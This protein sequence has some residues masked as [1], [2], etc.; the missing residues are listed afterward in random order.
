MTLDDQTTI[1][2]VI[3]LERLSSLIRLP[4]ISEPDG[5]EE[6]A[7]RLDGAAQAVIRHAA[8]PAKDLEQARWDTG[9]EW[10]VGLIFAL[11]PTDDVKD[12]CTHL[13]KKS[14]RS[15]ETP[16]TT[17]VEPATAES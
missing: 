13:L 12:L 15:H 5:H 1:D 2:A 3:I 8:I 11:V 14:R 4:L 10:E 9:T 6:F 17:K 7:S 16:L